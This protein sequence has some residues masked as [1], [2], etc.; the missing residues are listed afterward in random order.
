VSVRAALV[1][2]VAA[3]A[4]ASGCGGD[5]AAEFSAGDP[6]RAG[7]GG[8]LVYLVP[9]A[10]GDLD[11]LTAQT[12]SAQAITRQIFEP[13]IAELDAPYGRRNDVAGLALSAS[14]S[15][16]F[17]V[18]TMGL[19]PGVRFQD[20]R[21]LDAS[22]VLVNARRW[23]TSAV[24]QRLLPGL[25]AADG[26]RPDLVRFVFSTP[27][28]DIDR[29]LSDP[30]LGLVSPA[31]L[32]PRTGTRASLLSASSAGSGPFQVGAR[33]DGSIELTRY[34]GWWGSPRD[35]GPAL[36]R[37]TFRAVEDQAQRVAMLRDGAALVAGGLARAAATQLRADPLYTA[38][39]IAGPY[40]LGF[41]RS[42]RGI[43]A[44]RPQSLTGVWLASLGP[45]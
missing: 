6:P 14:P 39:G 20:G 4:F 29:R 38:V 42:V 32:L 37:L 23:Q 15:G 31:A 33:R 26:P 5:G 27:V 19:R 7:G 25:I 12:V 44:W 16:D 2:A 43:D 36:D 17:R 45:R 10:P 24:G 13:L 9:A 28:R 11:P 34:R 35:L 21:L 3:A 22:A 41:E 18:W 40:P 8:E 30:R 1:G